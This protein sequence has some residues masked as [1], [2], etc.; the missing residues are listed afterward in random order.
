[1]LLNITDFDE[2]LLDQVQFRLRQG[3]IKIYLIGVTNIIFTYKVVIVSKEERKWN[4]II[5]ESNKA[6]AYVHEYTR[7]WKLLTGAF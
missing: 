7:Y 1:M 6:V 5:T 3:N 4:N 2:L